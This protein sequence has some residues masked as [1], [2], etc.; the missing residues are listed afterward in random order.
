[1]PQYLAPGV[2]VEEIAGPKPIEAVGTATGAFIGLAEKGSIGKAILITN[3]TQFVDTFGGFIPAG[4][5]AYAV[6]QFFTEGGTSCYVVRTCHYDYATTP[7]V[8]T[9]GTGTVTL[10]DLTPAATLK[11]DAVSPGSWSD[12]IWAEIAEAKKDPTNKFRLTVW[13]KGREVEVFEELVKGDVIGKVNGNSKYIKVGHLGTSILPP[14]KSASVVNDRNTVP[15]ST[16]SI[17]ALDRGLSFA[18]ANQPNNQFALLVMQAGAVVDRL[19]GLAMTDVERKVNGISPFIRVQNLK[20][21]VNNLPLSTSV[22]LNDRDSSPTKPTLAVTALASGLTVDVGDGTATDTF[23]LT[24]KQGATTLETFDNLT[25]EKVEGKINSVSA[26]IDVRNQKSATTVPANRPAVTTAP[27]VLPFPSQSVLSFSVLDNGDD[28]LADG[29]TLKDST[30]AASLLVNAFRDEVKVKVE[31]ATSGSTK[32]KLT[33]LVKDAVLETFDELIMDTVENTI[34]GRSQFIE[35]TKKGSGRPATTGNSPVT[36]GLVDNDF[37]GDA[38]TKNG[39]YAFDTVDDINIVAIPDRPGDREVII[40]AYSYCQ[41]RKDCFFVADSPFGLDPQSVLAFKQGTGTTYAGNAFNSS[42]GALYYPWV[43]VTDPLTGG[44]KF[45]P[46]SGAVAGTYSSTDVLRGV[47]KAPAGTID[48]YLNSVVGIELLV[49][50][51]E[52]ELLNPNH[53]NV[54]RSFPGSGIVIWGARTLSADPEWRYVNVRRLL[55]FIEESIDEGSQW[56]VFEP[57]DRSLW[58]RVK[59]DITAFLT[60]VWR[61]GALFGSTQEEAFFVKI[62]DENNPVEVRDAG[63]LIIDI[64]VAPVKPAEFVIFRITQRTPANKK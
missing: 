30:P 45:V 3:W 14:A 1:M 49:T 25:I 6:N 20:P 27:V 7:A 50:K 62:D 40:A 2:Y 36:T 61:S 48:G 38:A 21:D 13:Y 54:I 39:L 56:V 29:L 15:A 43:L 58:A 31:D 51:G 60:N 63:Q 16:L 52:Q 28:G 47:H 41:N 19:S 33:V 32:F 10:Q 37:I 18:I 24:I 44:N 46:P 42:Y 35:V 22:I 9:A 53:V 64:A 34:N 11:V 59:R 8:H 17:T 4:Y 57:N 5:L 26:Y 23:K 12:H 55:L